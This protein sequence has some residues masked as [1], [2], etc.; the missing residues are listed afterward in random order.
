MII[1]NPLCSM[2]SFARKRKN[3]IIQELLALIF[4][5]ETRS[6]KQQFLQRWTLP[7]TRPQIK[8]RWKSNPH[9]SSRVQAGLRTEP[10]EQVCSPW[11]E[12]TPVNLQGLV[13]SSWSQSQ[14]LSHAQPHAGQGRSLAYLGWSPP[15]ALTG[16][17]IQDG[18]SRSLCAWL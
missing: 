18:L 17:L 10:W 13:H 2:N 14:S 15:M 3:Q 16:T 12:L 11:E 8:A 9:S 1:P 7:V 6:M 4:F 5:S